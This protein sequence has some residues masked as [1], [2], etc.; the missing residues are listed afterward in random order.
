MSRPDPGV[1]TFIS[2]MNLIIVIITGLLC[3]SHA[4]D[5]D[6]PLLPNNFMPFDFAMIPQHKLLFCRIHKAGSSALNHL[7]PAIAPPPFPQ[8]PTWT[9]YQ[10]SDYGLHSE[11]M[12]RILNDPSWVKVVI[13][14][15]PLERFLSAYRSK[16]EEFDQDNVC[17]DV[18]H[19][20]RPTFA[21]AIRRLYLHIEV[22]PDSHFMRQADICNLRKTLPYFDEKFFLE[23]ATSYENIMRI[24]DHAHIPI[25][26]SLN[27][28]IYKN[29]PPPGTQTIITTHITHSAD[30]STLLQY[31]DHD[32]DIKL[33]THYYQEDYTL[34][35]L[36]APVWALDALERVTL[37]ECEEKLKAHL[38]TP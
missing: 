28:T 34:L 30:Y 29:F 24:L 19:K 35:K 15:D 22:S 20:K 13:Y 36:P 27:K 1:K 31:Y 10:T 6:G 37:K 14:R 25:T 8:H 33:M 5:H 32:C 26:D 9:Y 12:I 21:E 2:S 23:P 18:F 11:D 7:L 17:D 4:D 3:L 16:C 38:L